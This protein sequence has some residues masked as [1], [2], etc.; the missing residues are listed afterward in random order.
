MF[1]A[2]GFYSFGISLG[3]LL[4]SYHDFDSIWIWIWLGLGWIWFDFAWIWL[5]FD[6]DFGPLEP[7]QLAQLS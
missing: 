5:G 1:R 3:F 6:L 4:G 2:L 7:S